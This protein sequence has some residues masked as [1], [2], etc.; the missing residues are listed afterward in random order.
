MKDDDADHVVFR[1]KKRPDGKKGVEVLT[2]SSVLPVHNVEELESQL[3]HYS[4]VFMTI[5]T[6][7]SVPARRHYVEQIR[8]ALRY[9]C[10]KFGVHAPSWLKTDDYYLNHLSV[11]ERHKMFGLKPLRIGEFQKV[12]PLEGGSSHPVGQPE[13]EKLDDVGS[14]QQG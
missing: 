9:Y 2:P 1:T 5:T 4:K 6:V 7:D 3:H 13:K 14:Q 8:P 11:A 12:K 10:K